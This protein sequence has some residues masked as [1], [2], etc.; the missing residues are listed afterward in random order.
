MVVEMRKELVLLFIFYIAII[1]LRITKFDYINE[2]SYSFLLFYSINYCN[3]MMKQ[4]SK[5]SKRRLSHKL[6][7]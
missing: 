4:I 7:N 1:S 3:Y 6:K 2:V 5:D